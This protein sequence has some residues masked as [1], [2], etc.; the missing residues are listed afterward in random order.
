MLLA[1]FDES[2]RVDSERV[3]RVSIIAG[4]IGYCD[5][6]QLFESGWNGHLAEYGVAELHMNKCAHSRGEF[7]GWPDEQRA[8]F[9]HGA[10]DLILE[11]PIIGYAAVVKLAEWEQVFSEVKA[12]RL[13]LNGRTLSKSRRYKRLVAPY[14]LCIRQCISW[15]LDNAKEV[16]ESISIV[17]DEKRG[18]MELAKKI[19]SSLARDRS[20]A[21]IEFE[22]NP[23][24]PLQAA[25][26][27]AYEC[28]RSW[29]K[30]GR[31]EY[32]EKLKTRANVALFTKQELEEY[33][34]VFLRGKE[35]FGFDRE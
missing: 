8:E 3:N 1:Y 14:H 34:E 27:L 25:D 4:Y 22:T 20:Q 28:M 17:F 35:E 6:W 7:A 18:D 9:L 2:E 32:F 12:D 15:V 30:P 10:A 5:E 16:G 13:T 11:S 33:R 24:A 26:F 29:S 31:H 21:Q 19:F 23:V